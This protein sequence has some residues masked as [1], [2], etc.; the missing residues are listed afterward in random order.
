MSYSNLVLADRPL[1]YWGGPA[2]SRKN[3]LSDN[4]YSI[5]SSTAGWTALD[6]T[7]ISRTTSDSW[8]GSASL[9][10]TPEDSSE[11]GF[12]ISSGSRPQLSYGITYTMVARVK[13]IS[14]S[15]T[16]KFRIEYLTTQSGSTLSQAVSFSQEFQISNTE[17]TT[18]YHTET[19]PTGVSA[20]YFASWGIVSGAGSSSDS[21]LFDGIQFFEGPPYS[22]YDQQY[23]NDATLRYI[24]YQKSKPIIFNGSESV[25]LNNDAILEIPNTYKLF[26]KGA[27]SKT[28]SIDFWFT[29]E[30]PP[31]Y[32]HKLLQIGAFISC[33]IE[34]DKVYIDYLGTR[35]F[36]Q[37]NDW[38]MQHYVNIVYSEKNILLHMDNN[39]STSIDLGQGFQFSNV[40]EGITPT[41]IVGPASRPLNILNNS[42]FEDSE[43]GWQAI[44][45][46]IDYIS[47]DKFSGSK[48][49]KITKNATTG[50]G[51]E[52][53]DFIPVIPYNK[54][55]L[56]AYVKIPS[57][58][59]LSTLRLV[60]EEYDSYSSETL[61]KTT[62]QDIVM[63]GNS[64]Q[65]VSLNFTPDITTSIVKVKIIQPNSGTSGEV[66]LCDSILLEKS[67]SLSTW[68][69]NLNDSD[70]IFISDI[71]L[72]SYDI[73]SEKRLSRYFY[74]TVDNKDE[75]AIEYGADI[76]GIN[77]S[78]ELS[79][80]E[81]NIISPEN[82]INSDLDNI[83][84]NETS[85]LMSTLSTESISIG[86]DGGEA[87]LN[88]NGI[89]FSLSAF[90]PLSQIDGYFNPI[91]STIRMQTLFDTNSGDGTALLIG[92]VLD[93]YGL[94]LRKRSN[95]LQLVLI[96]DIS[97]DPELLCETSTLSDG[98]VN[99]AIN[100]ENQIV[101]IKLGSEEFTSIAIPAITSNA[102]ISIGNIP[103]SL[104]A[105]PDY[106]RNFA[107]DNLTNFNNIDWIET[108]RYMLRLND[109]LNVSQKSIFSY[110]SPTL[111]QANNSIVTFN[112]SSQNRVRINNV[113][114]KDITYI[115]NFNYS[116]P[117]PVDIEVTLISE[118]SSTDRKVL[119]NF[120]ISS[121][122]SESILSSTSK[123]SL[124]SNDGQNSPY[125]MNVISSNILSH[126]DNLGLRFDKLNSSGC[127]IVCNDDNS[128]EAIELVFKINLTP[129]S[130]E[131]YTIID[132]SGESN[133]NLKYDNSGL[134]KNGVYDLYIDGELVSNTSLIDIYPGEIYHAILHFS[135]Q[136]S[137]DAHIG[138]N[139]TLQEKLDGT[140]GKINIYSTAPSDLNSFSLEKYLD[141]IGTNTK[142]IV[143]G[144]ASITDSSLTQEYLRDSLG[145]YY[146]MI[147]LP[148]VRIVSEI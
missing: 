25:R 99:I 73:G 112:T 28:A 95:K 41:I 62:T 59:E 145:E 54:Y 81:I 43:F 85:L 38:S 93:S 36:I 75:L 18:I 50:S 26:I 127:K 24:D 17:W 15:R 142:T 35:N 144:S 118:N 143:G 39:L 108:G 78:S 121:Y 134:I 52:S 125:I 100:L 131:I 70:P 30:R 76:L 64:W 120:Y 1:G 86:S 137:A 14:G 37:I 139:K 87:T 124:N 96:E 13:N 79:E 98:L 16:A 33:Y 113:D 4:Q 61:L 57:S 107:I 56:S 27:E 116:N 74:G 67:D 48:C 77:Y 3:L 103:E 89:K 128:Y 44:D 69:E 80:T 115:P 49:L 147:N 60:C 22:M 34:N 10:V 126:D 114:I 8:I 132:I 31:S 141:L 6:N 66:F 109:S 9:L 92:G 146:Q 91:S 20:N 51:F 63:D 68:A 11:A 53:S 101:S 88:S 83:T 72:Y 84:Y 2:I 23:E 19:V 42:S 71:G 97:D 136:L 119:N 40:I 138:S 140:I 135:T 110:S 117:E 29:L 12:K 104:D 46:S 94:S 111:L 90:L 133:I 129:N 55:Y 148:K 123:F 106:I 82:I 122:N 130:G 105:Y 47:S 58:N 45:S 5:E 32:K 7:T 102:T 65:R 21:I